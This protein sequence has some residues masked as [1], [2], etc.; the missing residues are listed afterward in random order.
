[1]RYEKADNLLQLAFDMQASRTG[2]SLQD[3]QQRYEVGRRTAMRMRDAIMR[4]F[5]HTEEV[6]TSEK[7]KRWRIPPGRLNRLIDF[8]A[9]EFADLE[10]AI[11]MLKRDNL[12]DQANSLRRFSNKRGS[13]GRQ[14]RNTRG[15]PVPATTGSA[16][17]C[18]SSCK[19]IINGRGSIS[20]LIGQ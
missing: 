20:L 15:L 16:M 8:S 4:N 6:V 10:A 13:S 11:A 1:M 9:E 19:W 14:A 5:P 2:L 17:G 12:P 18:P 3:I 7:V